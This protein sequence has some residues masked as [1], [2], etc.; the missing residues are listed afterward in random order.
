MREGKAK[1]LTDQEFT[2]LMKIAGAEMYAE[3][4]VGI[5]MLSFGTGLR[6]GE[7]A[8]LNIDDVMAADGELRDHF[9]IK[10]ANSKTRTNREVFLTNHKVRRSLITYLEFRREQDGDVF[11]YEA[12]LFRT[13]KGLRFTGNTMQQMLKRLFVK[14]GLPS[15]V[16]SHSGRRGFATRLISSGVDLKSVQVLMGHSSVGQTGQYVDT[17]P[18]ILRLVAAKAI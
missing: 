14:A 8:S 7:V 3:R 9:Q 5:I 15:S 17:N 10:R 13:Q 16:S 4:N 18:D 2:R 12:P 11:S 6:V 1:V